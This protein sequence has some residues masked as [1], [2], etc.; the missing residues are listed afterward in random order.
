[1][2]YL[3]LALISCFYVIIQFITIDIIMVFDFTAISLVYMIND[4]LQDMYI[5]LVNS[6]IVINSKKH[7]LYSKSIV[8]I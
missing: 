6:L 1:M 4:A 7:I 3:T 2:V 5:G 8:Y